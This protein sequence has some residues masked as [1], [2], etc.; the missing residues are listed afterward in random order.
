VPDVREGVVIVRFHVRTLAEAEDNDPIA[1]PH[2]IISITTPGFP[3]ANLAVNKHILGVLRL[4]FHDLDRDPGP[5]FRAVYGVPVLFE[6]VHAVAIVAFMA[7]FEGRIGDVV[8]H[9]NAGQSRSPAVAAALARF[10]NG[11]D[12]EF[13][14]IARSYG[15]AYTP[16]R[17]VYRTL[18][19][20]LTGEI[21]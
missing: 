12:R 2:V 11:D 18:L 10:Y 20:V 7:N 9:C 14:P 13:F 8:V 19:N 17:L 6:E 21:R 1:A 16:N 3:K 5:A 15:R 4:A